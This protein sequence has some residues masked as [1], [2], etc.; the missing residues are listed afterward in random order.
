MNLRRPSPQPASI[1]LINIRT[2]EDLKKVLLRQKLCTRQTAEELAK[3]ASNENLQAIEDEPEEKQKEKVFTIMKAESLLLEKYAMYPTMTEFNLMPNTPDLAIKWGATFGVALL[4]GELIL[5]QVRQLQGTFET[6]LRT[7]YLVLL[8]ELNDPKHEYMVD[9]LSAAVKIELTDKSGKPISP[10]QQ[11]AFKSNLLRQLVEAF[12]LVSVCYGIMDTHEEEV[13][14]LTS[15][16]RRVMLHLKD[17]QKYISLVAEA[18][19]R[20]QNEKP[21]ESTSYPK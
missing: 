17:A 19:K 2:I 3:I 13:Y 15:L 12:C 4:V 7:L 14:S 8:C 9:S 16:G 6:A 5:E 1:P 18:H 10:E 11:I 21:T 20:F